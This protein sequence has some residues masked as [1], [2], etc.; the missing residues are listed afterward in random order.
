MKFVK[1]V[2]GKKVEVE[3]EEKNLFICYERAGFEPVTTKKK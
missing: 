1:E 3:V 2:N